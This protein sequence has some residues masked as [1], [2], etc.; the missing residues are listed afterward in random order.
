M[1]EVN[2]CKVFKYA[3][4]IIE[5]SC[6]NAFHERKSCTE[7]LKQD[8]RNARSYLS[9]ECLQMFDLKSVY[10]SLWCL[11]LLFTF[12]CILNHKCYYNTHVQSS[13]IAIFDRNI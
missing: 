2:P 12:T 5:I 11:T 4:F 8:K 1:N 3:T 7:K 13:S 9:L 10:R 6:E